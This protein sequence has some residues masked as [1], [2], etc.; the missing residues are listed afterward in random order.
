[1]PALRGGGSSPSIRP[2]P[3]GANWRELVAEGTSVAVGRQRRGRAVVRQLSAGRHAAGSPSTTWTAVR[4]RDV[5]LPAIGTA[6]GFA[7]RRKRH[8]RRSTRSP[9]SPRRRRSTATTWHERPEHGVPPAAGGFPARRLRDEAGVLSQ[10]GRHARADVH[11]APQGRASRR[12]AARRCCTAT[13]D[14]TSR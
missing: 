10:P 12:A 6:S 4:M 14:S 3:N 9:T 2:S 8:A 11:H 5:P 1:M 7:G 13:A